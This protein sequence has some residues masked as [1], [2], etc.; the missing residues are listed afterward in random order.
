MARTL[1]Q[2]FLS[3]PNF[4][5][6][7]RILMIPVVVVFMELSALGPDPTEREIATSYLY[8]F[9]AGLIFALAAVTDWLDGWLARNKGWSSVV[10]KLLDPVADKLI[11]MAVL[12]C[13]TSLDRAPSWLVILLLAREISIT[14]LRSIA[15]SEG[16]SI[17]VIQTGKWKTAFQFTGLI[18]LLAH[19]PYPIDFGFAAVT[20]DFHATG[21]A[22]VL[23][24]LAFSLLSAVSYFGS[25]VR[26]LSRKYK[27]RAEADE[28]DAP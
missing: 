15:S 2:E 22:L 28:G 5:T 7:G 16:L 27:E 21:M 10:G 25:F 13:L 26:S 24:S 20:L 14:A 3:I 1:K 12:V 4:L 8:C 17:D 9:M 18:G 19:Y 11:V 6:L 23:L